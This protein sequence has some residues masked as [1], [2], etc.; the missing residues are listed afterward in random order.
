MKALLMKNRPNS[1][2]KEEFVKSWDNVGW[3]L[4]ALYKTLD[5]LIRGNNKVSPEDFELANHYALLAYQ[6]GMSA[7]YKNVQDML[8]LSARE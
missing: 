5:E 3:A 4:S 7:A 1:C 6:A 8:P 2:E